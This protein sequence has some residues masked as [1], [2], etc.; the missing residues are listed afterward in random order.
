MGPQ[1]EDDPALSPRRAESCA[2]SYP[3]AKAGAFPIFKPG[4]PR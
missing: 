3:D 2:I 4:E 1:I